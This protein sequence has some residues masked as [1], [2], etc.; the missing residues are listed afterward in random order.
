M[1][2]ALRIVAV[3]SAIVCAISTVVLGYIYLEEAAGNIVKLKDR[4]VGKI[5]RRKAL[6]EE[7][8]T[9]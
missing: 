5:N 9:V 1:K 2:K 4:V 3:A 8:D 7:F 6:E